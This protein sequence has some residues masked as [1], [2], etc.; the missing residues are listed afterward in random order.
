M[1]FLK[2][3][4]SYLR[5]DNVIRKKRQ[6]SRTQRIM[7]TQLQAKRIMFTRRFQRRQNKSFTVC[8]RC[9]G[10][11]GNKYIAVQTEHELQVCA[12]EEWH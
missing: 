5:Q 1:F 2:E 9:R 10:S 3:L 8:S 6:L 4:N 7:Q 11:W 12:S